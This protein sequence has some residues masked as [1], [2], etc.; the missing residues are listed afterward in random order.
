MQRSRLQLFTTAMANIRIVLAV[1][2]AAFTAAQSSGQ[3]PYIWKNVAVGGGGYATGIFLHPAQQN[4]A[5]IRGDVSGCFRWDAANNQWV[6][7][8]DVFPVDLANYY[9]GEAMAVDPADPNI[10]YMA[11]GIYADSWGLDGAIFKSTNQ[12]STWT[13]CDLP[14]G[15]RMG[16]NNTKRWNGERLVVDPFN[17]SVLFF[18]SRNDGLF[19]STNAGATWVKV[20]S[21]PG[22]LT[23][24][25]G[26]LSVAFDK[27]VAGLVYAN[28]Y[29][30]GVYRS[31][32]SGASWT[33]LMGSPTNVNRMAVASNGVV[34]A[35]TGVGVSKYT[36]GVWSAINPAARPFTGLGINP[37]NPL[38]LLVTTGESTSNMAIYRST[39][40]GSSWTIK[41]R[42]L[43]NT[44]PWYNS[45]MLTNPWMAAIEFDPHVPGKAWFSDWYGVWQTGDINA[46]TPVWTNHVKGYE[47][48]VNFSLSAPPS[49]SLL[50]SGFAD[51]D[52]FK[53]NNGLDAYPTKMMANTGNFYFQDTYDI[54]YFQGDPQ[55]M[56]RVGSDRDSSGSPGKGA[57]SADGGL[58]WTVWGN[59]WSSSHM[60]LRVAISATNANNYVAVVS[61]GVARYTT[62]NGGAWT[63]V[64]GL[65]NGPQGPWFFEQP[66][67][68]DAVIGGKY[69]YYA[70]GTVYRSTNNGANFSVANNG[71]PNSSYFTLKAFPGSADELWLGLDIDGLY[72]STDGGSTFNKLANVNACRLLT[73]GK[74]QTPGGTP[75]L[76]VYG[77]VNDTDGIFRSLDRGATWT[78]AGDPAVPIGDEPVTMEGSRQQFGLVFVGTNGRGIYYGTPSGSSGVAPASPSGLSASGADSRVT[79]SWNSVPGATS[80]YVK[81]SLQSGGPY[82]TIASGISGTSYTDKGL[83]NGTTY[84]Y[85]AVAVNASGN[86]QYSAQTASTPS[87]GLP[88]VAP[89]HLLS[90]PGSAKVT[91]H[92]STALEATSYNIKRATVSGGP[93]TTIGTSTTAFFTDTTAVNGTTYHYVVSGVAAAGEGPASPQT[94]ATPIAGLAQNLAWNPGFE[95]GTAFPWTNYAFGG[96][97]AIS[98]TNART[99]AYC[100]SITGNT[101]GWEQ[102]VPNL[103]PNTTYTLRA[104]IKNSGRRVSGYIGVN[105]YGGPATSQ[106]VSGTTY[107]QVV[108]TFTTGPNNTSAKIYHWHPSGNTSYSDDFSVTKN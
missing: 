105:S 81:R 80:Y 1:F 93:Y 45:F 49:G 12:G 51:V 88:P 47:S 39:N 91:L 84:Y 37:A 35:T 103:E 58:T 13:K 60:P 54:Q 36:G 43:A 61:N 92:W 85:V 2:M 66:L 52:G 41:G 50:F 96:S 29:G 5:Y 78:S 42:S 24:M 98:S 16:G 100:A 40:G 62:N 19:K 3:A 70:A 22:V 71:L 97:V 7:L 73:V 67:A 87:S 72:H 76:Y 25:I 68:A 46:A 34:Y 48:T 20:T 64:V 31:T 74:E 104:W 59:G 57:T 21:F 82:L 11:A 95:T 77:T 79:V 90:S 8:S 28:A 63:N 38:D 106:L 6:S 15:V 86:S 26:V 9:G 27:G 83:S 101:V 102:I 32:D 30:D 65:P 55:R 107:T 89:T 99:G 18:G 17:S 69:Y 14:A 53:H 4:L 10:V 108:L 44:V 56:V 94:S 33:K 75:A 23:P